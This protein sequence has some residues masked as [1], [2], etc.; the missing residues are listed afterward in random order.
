MTQEEKDK[1]IHFWGVYTRLSNKLSWLGFGL[2]IAAFFCFFILYGQGL[3]QDTYFIVMIICASL[4]VL[5][6]LSG[7]LGAYGN[8]RLKILCETE[9]DS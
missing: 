2:S 5:F 6:L 1:R 8:R 4:A 3:L 7:L 9:V